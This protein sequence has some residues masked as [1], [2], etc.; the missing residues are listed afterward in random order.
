M[1][2]DDSSVYAELKRNPDLLWHYTGWNGLQGIL[3]NH[4]IWVSH[5]SYLND[6]REIKHGYELVS[7]VVNRLGHS[8]FI[9]V[10]VPDTDFYVASF[11]KAFDSLGQW[12]GYP[13]TGSAFAI[14]FS[15]SD[16]E[17]VCTDAHA[18]LIECDY[19]EIS[20]DGLP[21]GIQSAIDEIATLQEEAYSGG[22]KAQSAGKMIGFRQSAFRNKLMPDTAV[23]IKS[24]HFKS[25]EETRL[26]WKP[27]YGGEHATGFHPKGSLIVPH[28][29]ISWRCDDEL[30]RETKP[31]VVKAILVGPTADFDL[32]LKSVRLFTHSTK[33]RLPY[34]V[35]ARSRVPY[36][37]W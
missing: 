32:S 24:P 12:R 35:I 16:L 11:S 9:Q 31:Y 27:A 13:G 2:I 22:P 34:P 4:E 33:R 30:L 14:G 20:D 37:N 18:K 29:A 23:A 10:G 17:R 19:P 7:A 26:I 28:R 1:T 5:V 36:R 21:P 3:R 6:V 15:K 8:G 25:E